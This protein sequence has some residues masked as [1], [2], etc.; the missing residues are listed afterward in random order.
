MEALNVPNKL[1]NAKTNY[2]NMVIQISI[3]YVDT[4][5]LLITVSDNIILLLAAVI[6]IRSEQPQP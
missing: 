5:A 6:N 4:L 1:L 3:D 2:L